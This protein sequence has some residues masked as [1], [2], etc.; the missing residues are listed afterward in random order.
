VD[1]T[2]VVAPDAACLQNVLDKL[3]AED[4]NPKGNAPIP[5]L[6]LVQFFLDQFNVRQSIGTNAGTNDLPKTASFMHAMDCFHW[7]LQLGAFRFPEVDQNSEDPPSPNYHAIEGQ[8]ILFVAWELTF[9]KFGCNAQSLA[10][11]VS[12]ATTNS[13]SRR[14]KVCFLYSTKVGK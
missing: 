3:V 11:M 10:A 13:T 5:I 8:M 2:K 9:P 14:I 7:H 12:L 4:P 6:Y 1:S